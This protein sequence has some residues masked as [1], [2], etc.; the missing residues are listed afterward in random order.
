MRAS[1][2]HSTNS[3]KPG[4]RRDTVITNYFCIGAEVVLKLVKLSLDKM[5]SIEVWLLLLSVSVEVVSID[6][7]GDLNCNKTITSLDATLVTLVATLETK[8]EQLKAGIKENCGPGSTNG[9]SLLVIFFLVISFY[10][11]IYVV[12]Y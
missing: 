6:V 7:D 1:I 11:L 3:Y 5:R 8:F 12:I 9:S 10:I 4:T 2:V